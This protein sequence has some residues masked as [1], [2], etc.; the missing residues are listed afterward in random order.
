M[1]YPENCE[2]R[3]GFNEVRQLVRDYCLSTMGQNLVDKMQV[4]T[5]H[6]QID[7][8][9]RQTKE[10]KSILENQEPLQIS[11]F[12]DIKVLADKIKVEGSYLV[13]E[14]LFKMISTLDFPRSQP[15]QTHPR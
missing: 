12:F 13:E 15:L 6:D 2:E 5:K 11:T 7:K 1:L 4:M 8:F 14:E 9:L 10:F 3:L